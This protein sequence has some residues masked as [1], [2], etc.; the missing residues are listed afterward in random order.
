MFRTELAEIELRL[1]LL[2]EHCTR[3]NSQ[4]QRLEVQDARILLV[5][6]T[7]TTTMAMLTTIMMVT[8]ML[9]L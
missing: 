8:V 9:D 6:L 1:D 3:V 7:L 5:I 4:D 2:D